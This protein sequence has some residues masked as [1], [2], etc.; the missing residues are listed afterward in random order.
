V[1]CFLFY[2]TSFLTILILPFARGVKAADFM[3]YS[4]YRGLNLGGGEDIPEKDFYINMGS[5]QGLQE[6]S[7]LQV[8]RKVS[9]HDEVSQQF[10][11]DLKFPFA[12]IKVIHV[13]PTA[14]VARLERFFPK[15]R[16]PSISPRAI[17][18]GDTVRVLDPELMND[19]NSK[20]EPVAATQGVVTGAPNASTASRTAATSVSV[21]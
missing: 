19:L 6:G 3:V 12:L 13:E 18:V 10:Y 5:A 17:M 1:R 14:A 7:V 15:D 20:S 16:M 4:V 2:L 9:S 8:S 11:R 21:Q